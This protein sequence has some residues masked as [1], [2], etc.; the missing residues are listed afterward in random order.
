M[1]IFTR[2]FGGGKL[3]QLRA[4][5]EHLKAAKN[6]IQKD[7]TRYVL[8]LC[9]I[10]EMETPKANGTVKKMAARAREALDG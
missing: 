8:A 7:A 5:N 6:K 9:D 1:S 3:A 10:S 4:E 2:L